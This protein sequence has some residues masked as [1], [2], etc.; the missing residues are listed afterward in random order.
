M[1]G[2]IPEITLGMRMR[3]A[4]ERA[5]IGVEEMAELL[6]YQRGA[7]TRWERDEIR[8]RAAVIGMYSRLT[9]VS[10]HWLLTGEATPPPDNGGEPTAQPASRKIPAGAT[11]RRSSP[12]KSNSRWNSTPAA[13]RE[14]GPSRRSTARGPLGEM[15]AVCREAA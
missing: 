3:V 13:A 8:P 5:K 2:E 6:G 7:P 14:G 11:K 1:E 12:R 9:G 15:P 4:R 10:L